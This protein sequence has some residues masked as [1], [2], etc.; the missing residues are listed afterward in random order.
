MANTTQSNERQTW[1]S[2]LLGFIVWFLY[3][4]TIYPLT[5]LTCH[6]GWFPF[7]ILGIPG[8][9]FVQLVITA[10]ALLL[11]GLMVYVP[12]RHWRYLEAGQDD[13]I[14]QTANDRRSLIAFVTIGLNLF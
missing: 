4:N 13:K 9:R 8:L 14:Y 1:I 6:W 10:V 7:N 11:I 2:L 5:S 12:W 3:F